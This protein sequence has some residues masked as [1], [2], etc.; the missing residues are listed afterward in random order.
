MRTV[1]IG[2]VTG[3]CFCVLAVAVLGTIGGYTDPSG[4][5]PGL[6]P[7]WPR[8]VVGCLWALAYFGVLAAGAGALIGSIVG[9]VGAGISRLVTKHSR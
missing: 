9:G 1:I 5:P 6:L 3:A 7:G 8:T 4:F 2:A